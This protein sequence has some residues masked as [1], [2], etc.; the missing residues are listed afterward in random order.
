MS[1][2]NKT[3]PTTHHKF[4][5]STAAPGMICYQAKIISQLSD[6]L[7][8]L[9]NGK[10]VNRAF[11]CLI[12]PQSG[13]W[14]IYTD[15]GGKAVVTTILSREQTDKSANIS[16][17]H[18]Q[19][20]QL[21]AKK[22][23]LTGEHSLELISAGDISINASMGKLLVTVKDMVQQIQHS[24]IQRCKQLISRMEMMDVEASQMMK[25]HSRHQMMTA[26]KD[27]RINAE[28]INMG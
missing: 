10:Q 6:E 26:D 21:A 12:P 17:P 3:R 22:L 8:L 2:L 15:V 27:I 16:L 7:W 20:M 28:R 18:K 4:T 14:V 19:D 11:S 1:A 5:G 9:D 23:Q 24:F 13:D 25:S